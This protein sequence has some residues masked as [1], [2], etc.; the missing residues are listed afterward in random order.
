MAQVKKAEVKDINAALDDLSNKIDAAANDTSVTKM[1]RK[2]PANPVPG[3]MY[4]P[5]NGTFMIFHPHGWEI[6][7]KD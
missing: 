1:S 7:S 2:K 3:Q 6:Y 5:G 4:W